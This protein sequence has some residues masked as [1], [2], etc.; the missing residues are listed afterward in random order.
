MPILFKVAELTL[1]YAISNSSRD[2]TRTMRDLD[3]LKE[4]HGLYKSEYEKHLELAL[5]RAVVPNDPVCFKCDRT[6][7]VYVSIP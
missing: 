7:G 3:M 1:E 5:K 2:N 4:R 6:N